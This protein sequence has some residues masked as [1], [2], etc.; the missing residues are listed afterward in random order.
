[1]PDSVCFVAALV[2][3]DFQI[4]SITGARSCPESMSQGSQ[5]EDAGDSL[6]VS[7]WS[8]CPEISEMNELS[9]YEGN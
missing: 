3:L 9:G 8:T 1:M 4:A 7:L 5:P 2:T 6:H